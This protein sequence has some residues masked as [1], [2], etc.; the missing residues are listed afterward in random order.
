MTERQA[1]CSNSKMEGGTYQLLRL[2]VLGVY[3]LV[4]GVLLLGWLVI[5]GLVGLVRLLI[6][7][8][9]RLHNG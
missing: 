9:G 6:V 3:W 7:G 8:V 5:Q 2:L 4:V 1:A